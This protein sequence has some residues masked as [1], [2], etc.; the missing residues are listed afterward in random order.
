MVDKIRRK[1][2]KQLNNQDNHNESDQTDSNNNNNVTPDQQSNDL[3]FSPPE[4]AGWVEQ[5]SEQRFLV[6]K[7]LNDRVV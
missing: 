7:M 2:I 1:P 3:C 4:E 6:D 5:C